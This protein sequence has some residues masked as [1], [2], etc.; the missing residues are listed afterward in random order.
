MAIALRQILCGS[1]L[2][3]VCLFAQQPGGAMAQTVTVALDQSP[4]ASPVL[5]GEPSKAPGVIPEIIRPT[6]AYGDFLG[7][8]AISDPASV[9]TPPDVDH[10]IF[11]SERP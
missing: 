4:G 2:A 5:I 1:I 3:G 8:R 11:A 7:S 10:R 6:D 9:L